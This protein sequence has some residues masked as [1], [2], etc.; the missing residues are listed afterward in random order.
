MLSLTLLR[1]TGRTMQ[2]K[3]AW[4]KMR[5]WGLLGA[6]SLVGC[7]T[8]PK[9]KGTRELFV[10]APADLSVDMETKHCSFRLPAQRNLTEWRQR[11]RDATHEAVHLAF[12]VFSA[13][14]LWRV[15]VGREAFD[16]ERLLSNLVF[17]QGRLFGGNPG[18]RVF[19][20]NVATRSVIWRTPVARHIDD[21]AKIG[22]VALTS[23][24]DLA[25][26]TATGKVALLDLSEGKIKA[27]Q[28]LGCSLRSAPLAFASGLAVQGSNNSLFIL[29]DALRLQ[30]VQEG[31]PEPLIFLGNATPAAST[32]LL[33]AASSTG[34]YKAYDL[35]THSEIWENAMMP[36]FLDETAGGML[37]IY[38]SPV[39]NDGRVFILGHGGR[40]IA[41]EALSGAPV[42]G[43]NF[44]GLHTPALVGQWLFAIDSS[45]ALFCLDKQ[46]GHVRW[47]AKLPD[48]R[49]G[50][51]PTSWTSPLVAGNHIIV[52]TDRGDI[53]CFDAS[54][55]QLT[56][57]LRTDMRDPSD[58]IIVNGVL[59]VLTARGYVH[60]FGKLEK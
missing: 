36:Q 31:I 4:G 25:V 5:V 49:E 48:G 2:K 1:K 50:I 38:A 26:T 54:T 40:L 20:V 57:T 34:E 7:S 53:T 60:A 43:V 13:Q 8:G 23:A 17:Y 9:I 51:R 46:T 28:E 30:K 47:G 18:G 41:C 59:Y 39:I 12:D 21:A 11:D 55:G 29:D 56:R 24:G 58:A 3:Q 52:V 10:A 45:G 33:F 32:G 6:L 19:A 16:T 14:K 42:W 35:T 27:T 22:G 44:S 15:F 37:H